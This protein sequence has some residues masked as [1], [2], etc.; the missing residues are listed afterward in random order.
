MEQEAALV[1]RP[2]LETVFIVTRLVRIEKLPQPCF[3]HR[4][5]AQL[6]QNPKESHWP[7]GSV[8]GPAL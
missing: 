1:H 5:D 4:E 8:R 7:E 2:S 6:G 3:L